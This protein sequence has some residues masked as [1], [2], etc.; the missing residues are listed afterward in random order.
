MSTLSTFSDIWR[1]F[2]IFPQTGVPVRSTC[3]ASRPHGP[4]FSPAALRPTKYQ[5]C[6]LRR[7]NPSKSSAY[8][9]I[10]FFVSTCYPHILRH[11]HQ[12]WCS[13]TWSLFCPRWFTVRLL[14]TRSLVCPFVTSLFW[15]SAAQPRK[16]FH[17]MLPFVSEKGCHRYFVCKVSLS[18]QCITLFSEAKCFKNVDNMIIYSIL[19]Y[20]VARRKSR[21][22]PQQGCK[23]LLID[24]LVF[25]FVY[26]VAQNVEL[27]NHRCS[28]DQC[29]FWGK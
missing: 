29:N 22:L 4:A 26:S 27:K 14:L 11:E 19:K 12:T 6:R 7:R 13:A 10:Y 24:A 17:S 18:P 9:Y 28:N 25:V 2:H 3:R 15:C 16:L 20:T 5:G 23:L 8:I 21:K 1:S